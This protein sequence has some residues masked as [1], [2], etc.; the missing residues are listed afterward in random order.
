MNINGVT[1]EPEFAE[2]FDMKATRIIITA[3][4]AG[5]A[6]DAAAAMTG[7]GT[8]VIACGIETAIE[9]ELQSR[10]NTRRTPRRCDSGLRRLG[11]RA[12]KTNSAA[13]RTMRADVSIGGGL[14]RN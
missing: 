9:R 10:R 13:H 4:D 8:S 12:G 5:W 11:Q 6:A 1:I 2:A 7:F 14:R 3:H